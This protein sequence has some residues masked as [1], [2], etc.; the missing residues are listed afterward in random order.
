MLK[1]SKTALLISAF[2]LQP[3]AC[4]AGN[5][6]NFCV[7]AVMRVAA[8][9]F[10]ALSPAQGV[11]WP[12]RFFSDS[13]FIHGGERP[14]NGFPPDSFY[15]CDLLNES[16]FGPPGTR[17]A[18]LVKSVSTVLGNDFVLGR[19]FEKFDGGTLVGYSTQKLPLILKPI[20]IL[21]YQVRLKE[22][23]ETL[24][25]LD[26]I[27]IR[28][29][30]VDYEKKTAENDDGFDFQDAVSCV[31][32]HFEE[33]PWGYHRLWR[34]NYFGSSCQYMAES[35]ARIFDLDRIGRFFLGA[36]FW[37]SSIEIRGKFTADLTSRSGSGQFFVKLT[38][39]CD[40]VEPGNSHFGQSP[41]LNSTEGVYVLWPDAGVLLGTNWKSP[42]FP[43]M[44]GPPTQDLLNLSY[45]ASS[46]GWAIE[47]SALIVTPAFTN[48]ITGTCSCNCSPIDLR[49]DAN[50]DG[51]IDFDSDSDKTTPA[52]PFRFWINNDHDHPL[53][54]D[55]ES[56]PGLPI[57]ADSSDKVIVGFRDLED[58]TT[59]SIKLEKSA[60]D[61]L[62]Q[63]FKL[64]VEADGFAINIYKTAPSIRPTDYLTSKPVALAQLK[65]T[66]QMADGRSKSYATALDPEDLG[67]YIQPSEYSDPIRFIFEGKSPGSGTIKLLLKSPTGTVATQEANV[68]LSDPKDHFSKGHA[69]DRFKLRWQDPINY[70]QPRVSYENDSASFIAPPGET[71]ECIVFVHGLNNTAWDYENSSET[72]Y[73]RLWHQG[74]KGRFASFRWPTPLQTDG[75]ELI[76]STE[77]FALN[78]GTA[79][80]AYVSALQNELSGYSIR[81]AAHSAGNIVASQAIREGAPVA[82]LVLMQAAVSGSA[83]DDRMDPTGVL[84]VWDRTLIKAEKKQRTP[85]LADLGYRGYFRQFPQTQAKGREFC[86]SQ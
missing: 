65:G 15:A 24:Q 33:V 10:G 46:S 28:A 70:V 26:R 54:G 77:F 44:D 20:D 81:I 11:A 57:A 75:L 36:N 49:V 55:Q 83:Y 71:K 5:T 86:E 50:R 2:I 63:G 30:G 41:P 62:Q 80:K 43:G 59:F 9:R 7:E 31:T 48:Q 34:S 23:A 8:E 6:T 53:F 19:F 84:G 51:K 39:I 58:F 42:Y 78:Y 32:D 72:M 17:G 66:F 21:N 74:F 29:T 27:R 16:Y 13:G 76:K 64:A 85:D 60:A 82:A 61:K 38:S 22:L 3:V 73:K 68:T 52:K 40:N 35:A 69:S 45:A 1:M 4:H 79:L 37:A 67:A 18:Q 25:K 47:D 56:R 14:Q 12:P